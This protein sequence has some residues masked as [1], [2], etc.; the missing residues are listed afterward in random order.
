MS[1]FAIWNVWDEMPHLPA[2]V[3]AAD[4]AIPEQVTHIFIDGRYPGFS[5]GSTLSTDG[6]RGFCTDVGIY[7]PAPLDE[8]SKR[9]VGLRAIDYLARP[10][11]HVVVLDG[12]EELTACLPLDGNGILSFTRDSD[13]M[14]YDRARVYAWKPGLRF[15]GRHF[16]LYRYQQMVG[17]L[18]ESENAKLCGA[19]I[20][21]DTL[22]SPER[23]RAKDR[24]YRTL[25]DQEAAHAR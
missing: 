13:S 22:R 3:A 17:S 23:E 11:D 12:D 20:H 4:R 16:T 8:C 19:G 7:I 9:T 5:D 18:T 2:H 14:T 6:T 25:Q 24:Y 1:A 15:W 21:H 10:G